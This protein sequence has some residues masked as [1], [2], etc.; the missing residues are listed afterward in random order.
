MSKEM[1]K[2]IVTI[3]TM[4]IVI[5][6]GVTSDWSN[7]LFGS[8]IVLVAFSVCYAAVAWVRKKS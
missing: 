3:A 6:H 1:K 7:W 8:A 5:F 2:F 4:L